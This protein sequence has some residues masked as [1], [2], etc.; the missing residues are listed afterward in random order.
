M[1]NWNLFVDKLLK[2]E[3]GYQSST[4]DRGNWACPKSNDGYWAKRS[5]N[6]YVC[7]DGKTATLIGTKYG[8]AAPT[9]C[10]WRGRMVTMPEMK[11]LTKSEA[12]KIYKSEFWLAN[13]IDEISDQSLAEIFCD[14]C[15]NHGSGFGVR[16]MQQTLNDVFGE[17]LAE[18][19]GVGTLTLA[20]IERHNAHA[21]F[22]AYRQKR[23]D[24]YISQRND[25]F[26]SGFVNGW[27]S[28]MEKFP[29][30]VGDLTTPPAEDKGWF[31]LWLMSVPAS[32]HSAPARKDAALLLL[33]VGLLVMIGWLAYREIKLKKK[34][35]FH[36][37]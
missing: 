21:V 9:L 35:T 25:S 33:C 24:W 17:S 20:A 36:L 27:L 22:N 13:R 19:G 8:I 10:A 1:A 32:V 2:L 26:N 34:L 6:S 12:V 11:D 28:R 16:M 15:V 23:L 5:G 4:K 37:H 3:G 14:G 30:F 31:L 18:D 29:L 7:A